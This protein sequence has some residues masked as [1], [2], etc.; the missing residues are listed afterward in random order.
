MIVKFPMFEKSVV[1][2]NTSEAVSAVCK[3]ILSELDKNKFSKD[4]VFAIH[5]AI[6]EAFTNAVKHG[7]KDDV[8]KKIKIE[9]KIADENFEVFIEDEGTG[10]NPERVPDPR[11][12]ENICKPHGRGLFLI[13]SYM[14]TVEYN[15]AGNC[16]RM[17]KNRT[18]L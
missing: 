2:K 17:I 14:D 4:D 6:E 11:C 9:Y 5:L 3:E 13:K 10:F 15:K 8:T 12:K 16:L 1:L 7:N 18:S